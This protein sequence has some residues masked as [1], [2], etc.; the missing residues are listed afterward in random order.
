MTNFQPTEKAPQLNARANDSFEK[1]WKEPCV[2]L[3]QMCANL[4]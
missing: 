4:P 2:D 3:Q 1:E